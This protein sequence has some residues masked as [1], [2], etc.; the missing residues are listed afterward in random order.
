MVG[1]A[2]MI[3]KVGLCAAV[4]GLVLGAGVASAESFNATVSV[5]NKLD[6]TSVQEMNWGTLYANETSD[7]LVSAIIMAP[8]GAVDDTIAAVDV[9]GSTASDEAPKFFQLSPGT[10]ARGSVS[11]DQNFTLILP[12]HEAPTS[13]STFDS[14]GFA[15]LTLEN[16]NTSVAQF[17]MA[18]FTAGDA[19]GAD[20]FEKDTTDDHKYDVD[21]AFNATEVEFGIGATIYTDG[22]D[23]NK[24]YEVGTYVGTFEVTAEY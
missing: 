22:S 10:P 21:P 24:R 8:D 6:V 7:Q 19:S 9:S 14:S 12:D 20:T 13:S 18:E 3:R 5:Q 4:G 16:G 1:N 15:V 23:A 17:F 11:T 2:G